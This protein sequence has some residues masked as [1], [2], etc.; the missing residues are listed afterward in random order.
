V[1]L[2]PLQYSVASGTN[3]ELIHSLKKF[4][5]IEL[6]NIKKNSEVQRVKK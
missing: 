2:T 3:L 4:F 6:M 1:G 5:G